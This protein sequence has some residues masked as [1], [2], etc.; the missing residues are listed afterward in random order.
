MEKT[1]FQ[2]SS[3]RIDGRN[4]EEIRNLKVRLNIINSSQNSLFFE[5][6]LNKLI[7]GIF[8][9][10]YKIDT[11]QIQN[12]FN[13]SNIK[14]QIFSLKFYENN[15]K[16]ILFLATL[17]R[18][19]KEMILTILLK[20]SFYNI[21]VRILQNDGNYFHSIINGLCLS[22]L[23]S[24][25]PMKNLISSSTSGIISFN[26][27]TDL[28]YKEWLLFETKSFL[29]LQNNC[30]N[31]LILSE[32]KNPLNS[33]FLENCIQTAIKSCFQIYLLKYSINRYNFK[34]LEILKK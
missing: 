17:N 3:R 19:V 2:L 6:G 29:V 7:I 21:I 30:E 26:F 24:S 8:G 4:I 32:N 20:N 14:I 13:F 31:N 1:K 23:T 5:I 18:I 15:R 25:I 33:Y 22:F 27:Y 10:K 34:Q 12:N 9:P 16:Y 28:T 11:K